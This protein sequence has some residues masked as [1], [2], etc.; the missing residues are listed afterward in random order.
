MTK[1]ETEITWEIDGLAPG[2]W[3]ALLGEAADAN[4]FQSHA[5]G[6]YKQNHGWIPLRC[7]GRDR[8]GRVAMAQI[9]LKKLPLGIHAG[10]SPGGPVLQFRGWTPKNAG[11]AMDSLLKTLEKQYGR[12]WVRFHSHVPG[13]PE[14]AFAF[15]ARMQHPVFRINSEF[16]QHI[17]LTSSLEEFEKSMTSKHR[18]YVRQALSHGISWKCG[19]DDAMQTELARMHEEMTKGKGVESIRVGIDEIRGTVS[20][21]GEQA[22]ILNGYHGGEAVTS[23]LVLTFGERGFYATAATGSRGRELS[24]AYAMVHKLFTVLKDKG[25]TKLDFAGLDPKNPAAFGVNHFK[26]GFGGRMVE[27]LGEWEWASSEIL[28]WVVNF[29]ILVRGG[30]L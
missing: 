19:R 17:D 10:W 7:V 26:R 29:G 22:L 6:K 1:Q 16:S 11:K 28:R 30:R 8:G 4:V 21:M 25:L 14:L 23:C 5:W 15:G 2:E 13:D 24:A 9:L 12:I 20:A 18:Y 27:Y 3:D